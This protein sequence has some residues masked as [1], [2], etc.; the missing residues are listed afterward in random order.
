MNLNE[1]KKIFGLNPHKRYTEEELKKIYRK[2]VKKYHPDNFKEGTKEQKEAE[3]MFKK[4]NN[5]YNIYLKNGYTASNESVID[6]NE[7]KAQYKKELEKLTREFLSY[8][9]VSYLDICF[10]DKRPV[11]TLIADFE[12]ETMFIFRLEI[13]DATSKEELDELKSDWDTEKL[14]LLEKIKTEF[15]NQN[16]IPKQFRKS[17]NET[18][19]K[20]FLEELYNQMEYYQSYLR[21]EF[22]SVLDDFTLRAGF[23]DIEYR[24]NIYV[25]V[26]ITK[27][28][29]S[30]N[31]NMDFNV[32]IE[33]AKKELQTE[34][35][36]L[37]KKYF[38]NITE[39]NKALES[40]T[41]EEL[42]SR[43]LLLKARILNDNFKA[44]LED[45]K[46]QIDKE[47][48]KDFVSYNEFLTLSTKILN[49]I[50]A[51][52]NNTS[53]NESILIINDFRESLCSLITRLT[54]EK[55]NITFSLDEIMPLLEEIESN[56][57]NYDLLVETS[58]LIDSKLGTRKLT[59]NWGG[60]WC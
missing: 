24:L 29:C 5:A 17:I 31:E 9:V 53:D 20:K 16:N 36:S 44:D 59:K 22:E 33:N 8:D 19:F 2:L 21:K 13:D 4:V 38:E 46:N 60:I 34:L 41:S 7:L 43:L 23:T 49:K 10:K 14:I 18:D 45:I 52:R 56:P 35:E 55:Y 48:S 32:S 26:R 40:A 58:T 30:Y 51:E 54:K 47:N 27:F 25:N 6:L 50:G 12:T 15:Y 37:Y 42:K 3:E 11:S 57:I 28:R 39:Y 1:I